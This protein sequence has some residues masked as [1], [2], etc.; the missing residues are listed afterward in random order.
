MQVG[1]WFNIDCVHHVRAYHVYLGS[2]YVSYEQL[3]NTDGEMVKPI[4]Q[5]LAGVR[6]DI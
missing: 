2:V 4:S 3:L 5:T 1:Q 6:T